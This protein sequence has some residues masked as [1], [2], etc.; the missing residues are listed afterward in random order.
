[1]HPR[2]K[3]FYCKVIMTLIKKIMAHACDILKAAA[4]GDVPKSFVG[5]KLNAISTSSD[6]FPGS[7]HITATTLTQQNEVLSNC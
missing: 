7:H 5:L 1:M 3:T 6:T 4:P 2:L